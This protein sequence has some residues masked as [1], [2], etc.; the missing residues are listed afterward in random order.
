M[1]CRE[2]IAV[3]CESHT[4]TLCGGNRISERVISSSQIPLPD[5]TQQS[6]QTNIHAPRRVGDFYLL[7]KIWRLRLGLNPRTWIPKASTL[8]LDRWSR[9]FK[10]LFSYYQ[11]VSKAKLVGRLDHFSLF[12]SLFHIVLPLSNSSRML[13]MSFCRCEGVIASH[14]LQTYSHSTERLARRHWQRWAQCRE[15]GYT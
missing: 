8:P 13:G 11:F 6:Q 9:Y 12:L 7:L 2:I 1:L 3:C 14:P 5:N 4:N 15:R 10:T